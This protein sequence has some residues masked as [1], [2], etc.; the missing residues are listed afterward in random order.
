MSYFL[1]VPTKKGGGE[2]QKSKTV[3]ITGEKFL[4]RIQL[5]FCTYDFPRREL[6]NKA[7]IWTTVKEMCR[8]Q[9]KDE[10]RSVLW[11]NYYLFL[12][13]YI[14]CQK[15]LKALRGTASLGWVLSVQQEGMGREYMQWRPVDKTTKS[16]WT[17]RDEKEKTDY[18]PDWA[19]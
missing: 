4:E 17:P 16:S 6:K 13:R 3:K 8:I 14:I 2:E 18:T 9:Y 12:A 10:Y 7:C 15:K 19:G 5:Y 1:S 11:S